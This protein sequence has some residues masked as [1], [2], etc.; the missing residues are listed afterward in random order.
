MR[1][2]SLLLISL[3]VWAQ[4]ITDDPDPIG[5]RIAGVVYATWDAVT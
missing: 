5:R 3:L 2:G 1:A 4:T